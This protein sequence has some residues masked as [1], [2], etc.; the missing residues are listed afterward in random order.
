[1]LAG[2]VQQA[3]SAYRDRWGVLP[4]DNTAA[5][6]PPAGQ[7]RGAW[8]S[9]ITVQDGN[10]AVQFTRKLAS[11]MQEPQT[12]LLRP[13]TPE[14]TPNA[15]LAWVCQDHEVPAGFGPPPAAASAAML[16]ARFLPGPCKR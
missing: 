11:D 15:A 4:R 9:G 1:M 8:V 13:V 7:L 2:P 5:G 16:A 10:I 14:G 3:V 12:L 6:L